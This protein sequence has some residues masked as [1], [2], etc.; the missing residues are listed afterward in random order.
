[1][2]KHNYHQEIIYF[3]SIQKLKSAPPVTLGVI[4]YDN[5]LIHRVKL[6]LMQKLLLELSFYLYKLKLCITHHH[7]IQPKDDLMMKSLVYFT[8]F[9]IL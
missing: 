5:L 4:I 6:V 3:N 9:V 1:M 8:F 2:S 7:E